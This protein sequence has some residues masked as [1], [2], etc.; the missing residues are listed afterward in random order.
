[1]HPAEEKDNMMCVCRTIAA[2]P[3]HAMDEL[4][5]YIRCYTAN[6]CPEPCSPILPVYTLPTAR[7]LPTGTELYLAITNLARMTHDDF[8]QVHMQQCQV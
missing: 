2:K 6:L 1:M 7:P 8:A 4:T 3:L 5:D